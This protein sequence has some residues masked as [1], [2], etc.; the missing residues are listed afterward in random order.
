MANSNYAMIKD[1]LV[2]GVIVFDEPSDEI[3][4][5]F[6]EYHS[7]D[8]IILAS[9]K[10]MVGSTYDGTKFWMPSPFPSWIKNEELNEWQAP[11]AYPEDEKNY[12]WN[13]ET[14][15]WDEIGGN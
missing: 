8:S 10:G 2:V 15:S 11:I 6:K 12:S 13:E 3:L 1:S 5:H 7:V 4:N 9:E 14:L